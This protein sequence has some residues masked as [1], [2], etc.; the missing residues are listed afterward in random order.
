MEKAMVLWS[1]DR[2]F[3]SRRVRYTCTVHFWTQILASVPG[4]GCFT[5]PWLPG[6]VCSPGPLEKVCLSQQRS[7]RSAIIG[8]IAH[9]K[10]WPQNMCY[11]HSWPQQPGSRSLGLR[12]GKCSRYCQV[13]SHQRQVAFKKKVKYIY[14]FVSLLGEIVGKL[15]FSTKVLCSCADLRMFPYCI[16][17]FFLWAC[18]FTTYKFFVTTN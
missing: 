14:I 7:A 6:L 11:T 17:Y 8:G 4:L 9:H 15:P 13:G 18:I 16:Y 2:E 5:Q 10:H 1:E 3:E 12:S